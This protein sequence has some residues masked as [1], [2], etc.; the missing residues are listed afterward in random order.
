M[1]N[2]NARLSAQVNAVDKHVGLRLRLARELRGL[3]EEDLADQLGIEVSQ[4]NKFEVGAHR[5]S[6]GRLFLISRTLQLPSSWFFEGLGEKPSELD[7]AG[8]T[9]QALAV[10][11]LFSSIPDRRSR[12]EFIDDAKALLKSRRDGGC[13]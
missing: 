7:I 1:S 4:L 5:I 2:D 12:N 11:R 8:T 9:D 10:V 3:S 6:A 13:S